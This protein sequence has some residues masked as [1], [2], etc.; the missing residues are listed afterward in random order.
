VDTWVWI[1]I[2]VAAAIVVAL[3]LFGGRWGFLAKR[4]DQAQEL[5]SEAQLKS[6]RA[7]KR[8]SVADNLAARA[9]ADRREAEVAARRA[10]EIDPDAD[11]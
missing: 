3:L 4:R 10:G 8:E 1:A 11:E 2:G 9:R 6:E 7:E 5:R